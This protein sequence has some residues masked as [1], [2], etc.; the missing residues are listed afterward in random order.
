LQEV[1]VKSTGLWIADSGKAYAEAFME[2]VN[3]KKS[4]LFQVRACTEKEQL[5]RILAEEEIEILLIS[6]EWYAD[7]QD[8]IHVKCMILLSEGSLL[9]EFDSLPSVYKYQSV[10]NILRE[11]MYYYSDQE[12]PET[13]YAGVRRE[14][15]VIGIYSPNGGIEKTV[16]AL[17]LGQILSESQNVLY[18]N[19]EEC[20]GLPECMGGSH[21]N[22]SDLIY[23]LRQNKAQFLYRLNSMVQ[24]MDRMD[25]IQ[26]C[27]SYMDFR[28]I[29]VEEWQHLLYLIRTQSTYDSIILD[30][31][32]LIGHEVD[33]LRQCDGIYVPIQQDVISQTRIS[34]WE[35]GIQVLDGMDVMEKLQKLELP[36]CENAPCREEDFRMLPQQRMGRFVRELLRG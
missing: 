8:L 10:E 4:H 33:L 25:Y 1:I 21:W 12:T 3:L 22:I 24:K 29:T 15:R 9:K 36:E 34:Q 27:E 18:L 11:V 16:F 17:T 20:A 13:F 28:Q 2:Y 31:G 19:L 35:R 23:F 5:T 32:N 30:M 26:P 7:C 6:A 14:N